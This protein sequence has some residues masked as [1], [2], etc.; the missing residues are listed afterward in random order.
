[1]HV[2]IG[3]S[4]DCDVYVPDPKVSRRHAVLRQKG[5]GHGPAWELED[6]G[7]SNGTSVNGERVTQA[8]L[9][10]GDLISIGNTDL[11]FD[12]ERLQPTDMAKRRGVRL[13][14]LRLS[15]YA[16]GR[17]RQPI[18][19][20][21][22]ISVLPGEFVCVVGASGAGK[23]TLLKALCGYQPAHDGLVLLDG[24]DLYAH[25]D[26]HRAFIGYVPQEDIVHR[27]LT[28]EAA[29]RY[30][31][32]LQYASDL[33]EPE[34]E[35]HVAQSLGEVELTK[36]RHKRISSLSGGERKRVSIASELLKDPKLLFMDEPTS[37]LDPGLEKEF[38]RLCRRLADAG[39]TIILITHA[40]ANVS[41]CD[42]VAFLAP[43]GR[44][45]WFGPPA[46]ALEHFAVSDFSDIY[47]TLGQS[48]VMPEIWEQKFKASQ[49]YQTHVTRR[50]GFGVP[51][52]PAGDV[53]SRV[54]R[55]SLH[56]VAVLT[57]RY[58]SVIMAD[59]TNLAIVLVQAPI[60]AMI[61]AFLFPTDAFQK[62]GAQGHALFSKSIL[63]LLTVS[64]IWF[65]TSSAA[66]EVVKE[67]PIY[68]RERMAVLS[69]P[70]YVAS[71]LVVLSIVAALQCAVLVAL[72]GW[73]YH[74]FAVDGGHVATIYG[75]CVLATIA[76][77]LM[78]LTMSAVAASA[79]QAISMTP[80]VLIAQV[81]L[82]GGIIS[83]Q[84]MSTGM[85]L[86]SKLT[87]AHWSL[88][89]LGSTVHVNDRLGPVFAQ[90][91]FDRVLS[92]SVGP[93]A[94]LCLIFVVLT[95]AALKRKDTL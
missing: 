91:M 67:L 51:A 30:A 56:Q 88:S 25:Y 90:P 53:R 9:Q 52:C 24:D 33:S 92:A 4:R 21:V 93:L 38:M 94:M 19:R 64:G 16:S 40:T 41:L 62:D 50:L 61:I 58:L 35:S 8:W 78:G 26:A 7:S 82:S 36:H 23:S 1:M 87:I 55:S 72:V 34:I 71:K 22:S 18:L 32:R 75:L 83:T 15:H 68:L 80:I 76:G 20:D 59:R 10:P 29:L 13:D 2:L 89:S 5:N 27:G 77:I 42:S 79:D 73:R 63:F 3:R 65:G 37:G 6:L 11:V 84:D 39:R 17:I 86:I 47:R 46:E 85:R 44:L 66:R 70:C 69:I 81:A 48:T 14:A 43:G 74:W 49:A 57:S 31:A 60:I 45:A 54:R 28:V 95:F 12:G